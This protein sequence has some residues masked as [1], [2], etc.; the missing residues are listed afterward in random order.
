[1]PL[2]N[3]VMPNP[4]STCLI[5]GAPLARPGSA[6]PRC[7]LAIGLDA[8]DK[9]RTDSFAVKAVPSI[10]MGLRYAGDYEEGQKG[11]AWWCASA[12]TGNAWSPV[13]MIA[14]RGFG[15][16]LVHPISH[17]GHIQ[18]LDKLNRL[19]RPFKTKSLAQ[20]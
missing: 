15:T 7:I 20:A 12:Q 2:K 17:N 4:Q 1:M 9:R 10:Q 11:V 8:P 19:L 14:P 6:C 16:R 13:R 3:W 18:C 5:C